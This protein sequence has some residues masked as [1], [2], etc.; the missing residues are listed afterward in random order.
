[1]SP[2]G[3]TQMKNPKN[4]NSPKSLNS[5]NHGGF[6]IIELVFAMMFL[7]IIILGVVSLQTS[8]LGMMNG[9]KNQIQAHFLATQGAQIVKALG[10]DKINTNFGVCSVACYLP[11]TGPYDI[12]TAS[13]GDI[14]V[15]N[16]AFQRKI[17]AVSMGTTD[18]Y[19]IRSIVEWTDSTGSHSMRDPVT[20]EIMNSHVEADLIVF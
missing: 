2:S 17:Q 5:P 18:S 14:T 16:Q 15:G 3:K 10:Y 1:M 13:P 20:D 6:S 7:T 8:N 19:K 11:V 12:V 9:Q 4:L